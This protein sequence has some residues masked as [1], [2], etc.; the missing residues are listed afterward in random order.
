MSKIK[1]VAL[2]LLLIILNACGSS[3]GSTS[4]QQAE[5]Q[6]L[7][8]VNAPITPPAI[9]AV[10]GTIKINQVGYL[11]QGQKIAIIP[12][13]NA[14]EFQLV[15]V[16]NNTTVFT[17]PLSSEL[18]WPVAGDDLIKQ[19]NFTEFEQTGSFKLVV[20]GVENSNAFVIS[21]GVFDAV[22]AASIKSYYYQRA[23]LKLDETYAG[24]WQRPAGHFDE[25]VSLHQSASSQVNK[26]GDTIVA[27]KGWYDAGDFG[28]YTVNSGI[29]TYTLMAAYED[30]R[31][32]FISL[33]LNIPESDNTTPD[34]LDE[35]KWNIDWLAK[36]Q[37]EDGGVYHKL[38]TLN[39]PGQEM[40]HT[41]TETR[42]VIGK[43]AAAAYNFAAVLAKASQIYAA[44][45]GDYQTQAHEWLVQA[46]KAWQWGQANPAS[47]YQQ[48]DDVHS[49]AYG[50]N[51][52]TD[53]ASWAAAELFLA[54]ENND[55]LSSFKQYQ[56]GISTPSWGQVSALAVLSLSKHG[57]LLLTENEHDSLNIKIVNLADSFVSQQQTSAYGIPMI[58]S[59]FVW[60]SNAVAAN[61]SL[62]LAQ[63]Y[64]ITADA[65]YKVS[66]NNLLSYVLGV[67]P[68][69]YSYVTGY[70]DKS[71]Q[72]I[73]HRASEAD[74]VT[75]PIPGFLV[76]GPQNGMQDNCLY[77]ANEP[78]TTYL[79]DWCSFST[80]EVAI[81][82]NAAL[83]Y[84]IA[85]ND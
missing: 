13:N 44:L 65:K 9:N 35:I 15:N 17:G 55:Y 70:G 20:E 66:I 69:G 85:A 19:A 76:G 84:L 6:P 62:I 22:L 31:E 54:T 25:N 39:W 67:N 74:Q 21:S 81:N 34:L 29:A 75:A 57:E 10:D 61:K 64:H 56:G 80:N 37:A 40:P 14:T 8:I 82:W 72:H 50:D 59:D 60:G 30:Y 16:E 43:S 1:Y 47:Y 77:N 52:V 24:I 58:A 2:A 41:D 51:N 49:G 11:N 23:G 4:E 45:D 79:D 36:M 5:K 48:P 27:N 32:R 46:E 68:T 26:N 33:N 73:H 3:G 42:Y 71:P 83:V 28:K 53:E 78:A 18:N 38:T 7:P 63:A 12:A